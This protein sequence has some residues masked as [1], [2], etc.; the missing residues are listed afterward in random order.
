MFNRPAR[1]TAYNFAYRPRFGNVECNHTCCMYPESIL[2]A[3]PGPGTHGGGHA[4]SLAVR[5]IVTLNLSSTHTHRCQSH[6]VRDAGECMGHTCA[7]LERRINESSAASWRE[8]RAC[9]RTGSG[10]SCAAV[11]GG[12]RRAPTSCSHPTC[13]RQ[14]RT[15]QAHTRATDAARGARG[16]P[17]ART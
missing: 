15:T 6:S 2:G 8:A 1:K 4:I 16:T 7:W 13:G 14:R 9:A 12:L 17:T 10:A 3:R 5:S 11:T